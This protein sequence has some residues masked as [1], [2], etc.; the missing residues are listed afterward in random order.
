MN[1]Q[2]INASASPEVQMNENFEA[3]DWGSVYA[4]DATTT[5]GLTW[6][7]LGG[8]WGGISVS[9]G[10]LA[11]TAGGGSPTIYNYIVVNKSTGA[12]SVSTS[13]AN[14]NNTA[15]YA[16]VYKLETDAD[17]V[18]TIEDHRCGPYGI[19]SGTPASNV[20]IA[21][22]CSD[23]TTELAA[24]A[25]KVKFRMPH[26]MTLTAVRAS[27]STAASG[28]PTVTI[29]V[30]INESS[31]SILS[32]PLTIDHG[33]KT[34]TTAAVPA[35]ISDTSL[36]DDAEISIDIDVGGGGATGLKVYLIGT[37]T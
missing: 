13:A 7:Y 6:G 37:R 32:T 31:G 1:L 8:R 11:L 36:A 12:I 5:T 3:L 18:V 20:V 26:A 34:S 9:A 15:E 35:V 19:H 33:E 4:K 16:R 22:A 27:L 29:T 17:S 28:S 30:D 2:E 25:G 10:T 24:G 21:I 14:W 23:E